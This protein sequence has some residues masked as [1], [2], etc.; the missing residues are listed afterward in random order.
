MARRPDPAFFTSWDGVRLAWRE[1]GEGRPVMLLHGFFSNAWT[2]WIRYGH[3]A[4]LAARGFRVI[5]PDLRGHG[6]SAKPHDP[7]AYPPDALTRDGHALVAHLGLTD[8]DLVGYSLGARTVSR[9]LATGATPRRAVFAGMGL[10]GLTM[11]GRRAGHFRDI[12]TSLGRHERGSAAWLAE[13]FLKTTGGDAE[14]LLGVIDTFTDTPLD[15][16]RTFDLPIGVVSGAEDQDNG[17]AADLAEALPR[18]RYIEVPGGHMSA[19]L[20]PDLGRAITD[21]LM[22]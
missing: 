13:Q 3:A 9:M 6:D 5:M 12:L 2:N 4:T 14:A 15:V 11:T 20:K 1:M 17:S 10:E 16:L 18:A 7:A 22:S 21:F 8:H 19:V